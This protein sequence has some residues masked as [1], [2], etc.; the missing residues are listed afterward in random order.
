MV[1]R[2]ESEIFDNGR[3]G[4]PR[5]GC[6]CVQCFGRCIIDY[7]AARREVLSRKEESLPIKEERDA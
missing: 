4:V 1:R 5:L 6:D 7:D 3:R 2:N